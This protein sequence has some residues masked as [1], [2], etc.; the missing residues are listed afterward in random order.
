MTKSGKSIHERLAGLP[1]GPAALACVVQGLLMH[2]HVAGRYGVTL[3]PEQHEEAHVRALGAMLDAIEGRSDAPLAQARPPA[4]RQVGVCRHFSLLHAEMLR[5]Q[6]IEARPRCG[7]GAY[8][9][10]GRFLDHWVTEYR[11]PENGRWMLADAQMDDHQRRLFGLA[12]E[13]L[14]VPRNQ[15]M[16]AGE[17]WRLCREG[18]QDAGAFGILDMHGL[19]FVAS[20]VIRDVAALNG[21][22]MLPWDVWGAMADND[23]AIDLAFIDQLAAL[24]RDPDAPSEKL[25]TAYE[26]PR[27]RVPHIVFNNVRGRQ[28]AV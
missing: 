20:N 8:F 14:E 5:A 25:A 16:V 11:D 23:D 24:S 13:P 18:R 28:E 1:K 9:E 6:G 4:E 12:F 26:D 27:I 15:F 10:K 22:V 7:F 19:W 3:R 17:A 21:R 2:Q